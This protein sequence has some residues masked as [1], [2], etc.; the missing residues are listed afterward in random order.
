MD[1]K[2]LQTVLP[3]AV[4]LIVF[5]V[6]FRNLS[7][8]RPFNAGRLWLAPALISLVAAAFLFTSPPDATGW[9]IV[10]VGAALGLGAG[11]LR[12]RLMHLE[13]D[14]AGHLLMRQS[15]LALLFL[16]GIMAARRGL[17]YELGAGGADASGHLSAAT[18]WVTD[19]LLGFAL[20]MV[21]AMRW[22]LWQRAKAVPP[23]PEVFS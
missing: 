3:I 16:V 20:A 12:G 23:H 6:R 7:K 22:V 4:I 8:P 19:G 11:L 9:A 17:A 18:L 5:A 21:I 14:P 1:P 13:R 2:T 10:V 15:P